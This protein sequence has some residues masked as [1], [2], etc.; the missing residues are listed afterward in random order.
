MPSSNT[1]PLTKKDLTEALG[2]QTRAFDKKLNDQTKEL[3][4]YTDQQTEKLAAI[5]NTA[6]QEQKDHLDQRFDGVEEQIQVVE[7]KLDRAL[8]AELTHLEARV[9]QLEERVGIKAGK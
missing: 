5:V 6:F 9:S 3:K 2:V 4:S 1:N 7:T 8:Y